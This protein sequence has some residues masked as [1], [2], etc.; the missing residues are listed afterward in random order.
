M[1]DYPSRDSSQGLKIDVAR[2]DGRDRQMIEIDKCLRRLKKKC[3]KENVIKELK[4]R[5]YYRKPSEIKREK[6]KAAKRLMEKNRK[7]AEFYSNNNN[8]YYKRKESDNGPRFRPNATSAAP[9]T[10]PTTT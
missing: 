9:A 5:Q 7:K 3:E 1:I 8:N 4:E 6:A 10:A 2:F